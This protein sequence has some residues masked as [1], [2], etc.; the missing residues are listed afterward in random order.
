[1]LQ[2][3]LKE[4]GYLCFLDQNLDLEVKV[5]PLVCSLKF[6]FSLMHEDLLA[7]QIEVI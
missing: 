6:V 3:H 7:F 1:M 4:L 5:R 2:L